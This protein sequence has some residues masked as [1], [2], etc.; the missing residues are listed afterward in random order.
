MTSPVGFAAVKAAE[1]KSDPDRQAAKAQKQAQHETASAQKQSQREALKAQKSA[2]K[3][4]LV[5]KFSPGLTSI[6]L[7]ADGTIE[8]SMHGSGSVIGANARVDQSGSERIFRDTRQAYLTIEG[9]QVSIAAKLSSN[10]GLSV[11]EARK[12]AADVNSLA[13]RLTPKAAAPATSVS[14]ADELV[15]L[16]DLRDSGVLSAAEFEAQKQRLL[17]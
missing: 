12:F 14:V 2:R 11:K 9:P 4:E 15:K 7:Y 6:R 13:Q 17:E 10:G 5:A 3:A 16:K 8:S 1:H